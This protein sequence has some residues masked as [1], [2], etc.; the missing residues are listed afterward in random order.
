MNCQMHILSIFVVSLGRDVWMNKLFCFLC[1]KDCYKS[2]IVN[3]NLN[4]YFPSLY[5][6][7]TIIR[8]SCGLSGIVY[9]F[10]N[11]RQIQT[12]KHIW[13]I[14]PIMRLIFFST[15]HY[16]KKILQRHF[17]IKKRLFSAIFSPNTSDCVIFFVIRQTYSTLCWNAHIA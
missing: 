12:Q 17:T 13:I 1:K 2:I 16:E 15:P 5:I 11:K 3:N 9:S 14:I 7:F 10:P 8:F 6:C 4:S